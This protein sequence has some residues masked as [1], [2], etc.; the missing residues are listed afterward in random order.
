MFNLLAS[1]NS[2]WLICHPKI[3][4]GMRNPHI[5]EEIHPFSETSP[6]FF[7]NLVEK[8]RNNGTINLIADIC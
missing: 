8:K 2:N 4:L 6:K 7:R 1:Q 3:A 5:S